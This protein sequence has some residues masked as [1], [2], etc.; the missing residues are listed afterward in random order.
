MEKQ[1]LVLIG[2]SVAG[3]AGTFLPWATINAG[4]L[5]NHSVNGTEGGGDGYI[6]LFL[7]AMVILISILGGMK[8]KLT[9]K[10]AISVSVISLLCSVIGFYDINS[11]NEKAAGLA[12]IG[13]GLYLVTFMGIAV[14]GAAFGMMKKA[15]NVEL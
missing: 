1:K 8:D 5:G 7:F 11:I 3:M 2:M 9:L 4:I 12:S 13:V 6:T 14:I 10:S 15:K